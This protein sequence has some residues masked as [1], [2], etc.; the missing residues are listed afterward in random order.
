MAEAFDPFASATVQAFDP[1]A[2]ETPEPEQDGA[3][4]RG[5][6]N[7]WNSIQSGYSL[8][9]GDTESLAKLTAER[10]AYRKANPGTPEGNELMQAWERGDGVLGGAKEVV[11]EMTKDWQEAPNTVGA[12]RATGK[13][14][15][16]MGGGIVEQIPN[17]VAPMAGMLVGGAAG[18]ASPVPGGML[19][20]GWA[21]ATA[22]NTAVE[23]GEQIDRALMQAGINPQDTA[24]V[25][26]FMAKNGDAILGKAATKGAIIGAVDTATM[27]LSHLLLSAPG[28]AAVERAIAA[29]INPTDEIAIKAAVQADPIFQ[30]SQKGL[31]SLA[32]NGAVAALE[33]AGEFTGEYIGQGVATGDW[34]TKGAALEALSSLGQGAIT[35]AGQKAYEAAT[36]PFRGAAAEQ[37][38]AATPEELDASAARLAGELTAY[39]SLPG[40]VPQLGFDQASSVI[41][42]PN[43][44][45]VGETVIDRNAGPISAA[46]VDT[47]ITS[48]ML[49][50][51]TMLVPFASRDAAQRALDQRED[52]ERLQ[53]IPHP[54]VAGR[55]AIAQ[56]DRLS[57][58][59]MDEAQARRAQIEQ[60]DGNAPEMAAAGDQGRGAVGAG[61][62]GAA[63]SGAGVG[64][65][66]SVASGAPVAGGSASA[67]LGDP[68]LGDAA[69]DELAP[70]PAQPVSEMPGVRAQNDERLARARAE[71]EARG[72]TL[73]DEEASAAHPT[74]SDAQIAAGNYKKGHVKIGPLDV[75]IENPIGTTRKGPGWQTTMSAHYGYVKRTKGA[76]GDQVDVFI[77]E[78][79][80]NDFNG[81]VYVVDQFDPK[82]GR[83]DEHKA[84]VGYGSAAEATQAYD[85]HFGDGSGPKR[86]RAV[87]TMPLASFN[88]WARNGD[89][90]QALSQAGKAADAAQAEIEQATGKMSRRRAGETADQYQAR[91]ADE[92]N[93]RK[94]R[95]PNPV[96]AEADAADQLR[97]VM[98]DTAQVV[99]EGA[100]LSRPVAKNLEQLG[101]IFGKKVVFF[102]TE[103]SEEGF[104]LRGNTVFVNAGNTGIAQLRL[105]G[106]EMLHALKADAPQIYRQMLT[107]VE[108]LLTDAEIRAQHLDYFGTEL[109]GE[110]SDETRAQVAEEWMADLSGN[111][112]GESSFW[113]SVFA[114]LEEQHGTTTAKG[115]INRLRLAVVSAINKL[116]SAIRGGKFS[117]DARLTEHLDQIRE[118]LAK[119][120]A[121]YA[122]AVKDGKVEKAEGTEAKFAESPGSDIGHKR[123]KSGEYVGAPAG[124][125]P[126]KLGALRT[127]LK[128]LAKEGE[129]GRFW[130]EESSHLILAAAEGDKALAEK[131]AGLL[132]I[133][134]PQATVS[135]NTSMGLKALYQWMDGNPIKVRFGHQDK[136]AQAWMDGTMG[137]Q[138][139]LQIKTGNFFKNLMRKI[140]EDRYGFDKQGAT[141]DMW[142]ARV[143]GYGSKAIGSEAR[144]L[145]AERETKRLA[146]ELGWE[147]QQV[148][149]ALWVAIKSR[150]EAIADQA[151]EIGKEKGWLERKETKASGKTNVTWPPKAEFREDYEGLI[152]KMA[153]ATASDPSGLL[154]AAYHFGTALKERVG[155]ISWEA[156]PGKTTGVLPGVFEA[157]LEQQAEYLVAIDKA[158]RDENGQDLIAKKL[159][160]PVIA[161]AMG[162]SAWQMNV[163]VGAQTEVAVATDRDQGNK[164]ISVTQPARELLNTYAAIRGYVLAQEAVVWHYPI[165]DASKKNANGVELD[166]G[167]DP[168]H[169]EVVSLYNAINA[170]S[171]RDDWAPAY[172]PGVGVRIL[173][174][175]EVANTDFHKLIDRAVLEK[176]DL[177]LKGFRTFQSDGDYIANDWAANPDGAGYKEIISGYDQKLQSRGSGRSDL[178]GWVESEL[179]PRAERVN[180]EFS[181]KYGW[182]K[183]SFST[184]RSDAA[185]N[186]R[187]GGV[188]AEAARELASYGRPAPGAVSAVGRHYS[189]EQRERLDGRYY[190]TGARGK[191]GPRVR[192]ASDPRIKERIYFYVNRG[193]GITPEQGVGSH[194][195]DVRLN[196]LY[197]ANA[198][199]WVQAKIS[200]DLPDNDAWLNA[201]ESAVIDNGFD[202]YVSDFGIQRAAVLLGRHSISPTYVGPNPADAPGAAQAKAPEAPAP[203]NTDADKVEQA[204]VLPMGQ[205]TGAEWK[206]LIPVVVPGVDV[207]MLD[208]AKAYYK[209]DVVQ[210]M[211]GGVRLS[212]AR[213][214]I[215]YSQ[216]ARQ[217]EQAPDR[218]FTTAPQVK[219]WLTGNAAKLGIKKDE[220]QWSGINEWLDMQGKGKVAKQQVLDYL[221]QGGVKVEEVMKGVQGYN[222]DNPKLAPRTYIEGAYHPDFKYQVIGDDGLVIGL[223]N[224]EEDA[225][226]DAHSGYPEYW[227]TDNSTK[228]G[229]YTL[230]GGE[231][232]RELLLTLPGGSDAI[233]KQIQQAKDYIRQQGKDPDEEYGYSNEGDYIDLAEAMGWQKPKID[234]YRSKHWEEANILAH[235]R[236]NE[237]TD[238]KGNRVLFIEEVQSDWGQAG[239]KQ[240]FD[241]GERPAKAAFDAF[242]AKLRNDYEADIR[243]EF[244][245][246]VKDPARLERVIAPHLANP[247]HTKAS[248]LERKSEYN[249]LRRAYEDERMDTRPKPGPFVTDTKSW[250]A[251]ALKRMMRYAADNGFQK[252]AFVNGEQSAE[253]YSLAKKISRLEWKTT[254]GEERGVLLGWDTNGD[255][256]LE[257]ELQP[258]EV[259]DYTG[260]E[261]A[262]RLINAPVNHETVR[263]RQVRRLEGMDLKVGGEGMKTFYDK[264]VPQVAGDLLKK[265]GGKMEMV[266]VLRPY[267]L[268]EQYIGGK[269]ERIQTKPLSSPQ[270]G[271]TVPAAAAEP[272]PL[273]SLARAETVRWMYANRQL[274]RIP[275]EALIEEADAR[276]KKIVE[277]FLKE[278]RTDALLSM[279]LPATPMPSVLHMLGTPNQWVAYHGTIID[280]VFSRKHA[281][282]FDGLT[283]D[284]VNQLLRSP[285]LVMRTADG[286]FE[287]VTD[288]MKDGKLLTFALI[289]D[290]DEKRDLRPGE[291]LRMTLVKS[292]YALPWKDYEY[293][294]KSRPG[295]QSRLIKPLGRKLLYADHIKFAE[296][297]KALSAP[298]SLGQPQGR[299]P[300][301]PAKERVEKGLSDKSVRSYGD[302]VN[303][304]NTYHRGAV[305]EQPMFSLRR[306]VDAALANVDHAVDGLSN[307]P[308]QFDYL[309]DRYLALGKIARVDEIVKEIRQAFS[310]KDER[311]KKAVYD[312]LTTRGANSSMIPDAQI[313]AMAERIKNTINYVGDQLVA[314]GLIDQQ[315]RDH[316][317]DQYLPRMYL[318]H[319][320]DDDAAKVMGMGKKPSDL[321]YVKHRKDIP[322]EIRELVLG[323]VKD[324][325]FLSANA[326]GRAMRDV[327][328]LDWMG[329]ISLNND[330]VFPEI[331]VTWKGK[332]VTAYWLK[333]EADRISRQSVHYDATNKPLAEQMVAQMRALADQT[334]GQM[335]A[336]DHKKYKQIPDTMRYGLLR[337]MWVR[338]EIFDD[339]MGAGQIMNADP[340]WFEDWFGVGGKGTKLTQWWKFTKVALNPPGQIRN[341]ISNMV[342]LQLSGVGLHRLPVLLVR[343]AKEISSNGRYWQVAKK[344]GVT[345]STF[346]AQELHRVRSDLVELEAQQGKMHALRWLMTAGARF[347]EKV[348][349]LYQFSEALGKT[350]KI[351]DEMDKGKTE[352]EAAIEAQK[353]LFDYSLVPRGVRIARNAPVGMPFI[354]YQIKVLPRLLEVATKYPWRFLPWAGLL[355]GMQAAVA[356]MFGVDDDD[357]E[358]L[359]KSLPQWLQDRGHTVFLP[360]RDKDG[361]IQVADVG[362]FFPWTFYSTAGKHAAE[363]NMKKLI[364]DDIFGQFSAPIIGAGSALISNYDTFTKRPI[365]NESDPV[366]YQAAAI[367]NYTYD[368]MAPPFL[369]SHG[370][371]SPMGLVDQKFGGKMVQALA[372]TTNRFGD[373]KATEGQAIGAL[374]GANFYGMDPEHTRITNLQVMNRKILDAER[375]LKTRLMDRGLSQEQ[376][377]A[378]VADYQTRMQELATEMQDYAKESEVPEQLRV[379]K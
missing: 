238:T 33:P 86:R 223:G 100:G 94:R 165:F 152:L 111:R 338:Q 259:E 220:V 379:R 278:P 173:N 106:H 117:V 16:A 190:G 132:A 237:R 274:P 123:T 336:I 145:F 248:Y 18:A 130:Y 289:P 303:F 112:F 162:P 58:Q 315:A 349:D 291:R 224:T 239:K 215:F 80:A 246:E 110:I 271:F 202:G 95:A 54:R 375:Q 204:R 363:G 52:A 286:E 30:A 65:G 331:F 23:S 180:Q 43:Q 169:D 199:T 256:V 113:E 282:D 107:S 104:F 155:Q 121:D 42:V 116:M 312:Y 187:A 181:E 195:H 119:G 140:D 341:F 73:I 305:E 167:R 128:A 355:Y 365:Y 295:V 353:W 359:K 7:A 208:D 74:P 307:L 334:L 213:Q 51:Q 2:P 250:V 146:D 5:A 247:D 201:F 212:P 159:G 182:G 11:G 287:V 263:G 297:T 139:A 323:E 319:M 41:T 225:I 227:D 290:Q 283:V 118:A 122:K 296:T 284:K 88:N 362:Y 148:Q 370:V 98:G 105:L 188:D 185:R 222:E 109:T 28:K 64:A 298:R 209:S 78:G 69:L 108:A 55:F 235:I 144:Y 210:A 136:K 369:S 13:N 38:P 93:A 281:E 321:G 228:Y 60:E 372:G 157:P 29:G 245:A 32:R 15:S 233:A 154:K 1:F 320:L 66:G 35:F 203:K 306:R 39:E 141:I 177:H 317:R 343:A 160:L 77:R 350:I 330:W 50:N 218:I 46:V 4:T 314:R 142:M 150:I 189:A 340:T 147:P 261:I 19:L 356:A 166:F 45:G 197:D 170:V 71:A 20:G 198:D 236:F 138:D 72:A 124:M 200:R 347:L 354:T 175:S 89:T 270:P 234:V 301:S 332:R 273:F 163:G 26:D 97:E 376:R 171:G 99:T 83:F 293:D 179:R 304:I 276:F 358:K 25:K 183:P 56:R 156:M 207:S 151:R 242:I 249:A 57:L 344:Y 135:A 14:L 27:G 115:I 302:L 309:K 244:G 12:L 53:I 6:K 280:K 264:I 345:E 8:L 373:P 196:N 211:R 243:S 59:A 275:G 63:S 125:T 342:M 368:L 172:V 10:D 40:D 158:L 85:Q 253:R 267:D 337:G 120:F 260:K 161:T 214:P 285:M 221:D 258:S 367:A 231:N 229:E 137:E 75:S 17:M 70:Q 361:R 294:G 328:L 351:M 129:P 313:R 194:A 143:F 254:P 76:D 192:A 265:M 131:V 174:F 102:Q 103:R 348:S 329:K 22:G 62:A 226:A 91:M 251:L 352:A 101:R 21:G 316:Y 230:P 299:L 9:T 36:D 326:I 84:M 371:V 90:T 241:S 217:I 61:G 81:Q 366:A 49:A 339:I 364:A 311:N 292:A 219:L 168:T 133:Y 191:E 164:K 193:N 79:T 300:A 24:A 205:M 324:P 269:K 44:D 68:L 322:Q 377:A 134:S 34:D 31:N 255:G 357:L 333:A 92:A 257:K 374:I 114:K 272:M 346:T 360:M 378:F 184:K 127:R 82:T 67:S 335:A 288:H 178:Q 149:A 327:A 308:G 206:R 176:T 186:E 252:I 277:L 48:D 268:G 232:Y 47:G 310:T 126:A 87:V 216:L 3:L 279:V 96:A 266:D 318:R 240:G 153:L 325:A 262:D 37:A